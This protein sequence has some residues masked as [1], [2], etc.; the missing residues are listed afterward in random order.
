[1]HYLVGV[2]MSS[3]DLGCGRRVSRL[4]AVSIVIFLVMSLIAC[5]GGS[6][7][8]TPDQ[9]L[10]EKQDPDN[11]TPHVEFVVDRKGG[12]FEFNAAENS[13]VKITLNIPENTL[14]ADQN[15]TASM[16]ENYPAGGNIIAG[17]VFDLKPEN[18]TFSSPVN[19]TIFYDHEQLNGIPESALRMYLLDDGSWV[20]IA[21]SVDSD[22]HSLSVDIT[23]LGVYA[24]GME[25]ITPLTVADPTG[26]EFDSIFD[27]R[28]NCTDE[29]GA[30]CD[31]IYYTVDGT[32]PTEA[33]N[34]YIEA[35]QVANSLTTL[36]YFATDRAGNKEP[37]KTQQYHINNISTFKIN[38]SVEGLSGTLQVQLNE[39]SPIELT[40][41]GVFSFVDDILDGAE[42]SVS[43][44]THPEGQLC[45]LS[46]AQGVIEG[47]NISDVGIVCNAINNIFT[48]GGD[49]IGLSGG[50]L[51]LEHDGERH[52]ITQDGSFT[53]NSI[54]DSN[55]AYEVEIYRQPND[56]ICTIVNGK[57]VI[58]S[59]S[60]TD[61]QVSCETKAVSFRIGG[62][63]SGLVDSITLK[64]GDQ[65][66]TIYNNG[67]YM[68]DEVFLVGDSYDVK[69]V[70]ESAGEVCSLS[71]SSG[72]IDDTNITNINVSCVTNLYTLS[73]SISGLIE[74]VEIQNSDGQ[75]LNLS[76]NGEFIFQNQLAHG[77]SYNVTVTKLPAGFD[78]Q[79]EH[80]S[81]RISAANVSS[82]I[83]SCELDNTPPTPPD[84]SHLPFIYEPSNRTNDATPTWRW[85]SSGGGNGVFRYKLNDNV[86]WSDETTNRV[87]T[88]ENAL[89]DGEHVFHVQERDNA[90]NWS[91][92]STDTVVIETAP[93]EV[94]STWPPLNAQSIAPNTVISSTFS[95][96]VIWYIGK[97]GL[98]NRS[99]LTL[100]DSQGNLINAETFLVPSEGGQIDYLK[101][102]IR[103]FDPLLENETYKATVTLTITD[104]FGN[105]LEAPFVWNFSTR[106]PLPYYDNAANWNDYLLNDANSLLELS[107]AA[108]D[109]EIP[110]AR[111]A[112]IH[113]GN[114]RKFFVPEQT[115]CTTLVA[116]DKLN[117]F[118]WQCQEADNGVLF[119]STDLQA[120]V[121]LSDLI[122]NGTWNNNA[123][124]VTDSE[125]STIIFNSGDEVWWS[126]PI[127]VNPVGE[128]SIDLNSSGAI[129][130]IDQPIDKN[131]NINSNNVALIVPQ[132]REIRSTNNATSLV[133]AL[134]KR[135][136]WLEGR[137][138]GNG[139]QQVVDFS[140]VDFSVLRHITTYGGLNA[141]IKLSNGSDMNRIE[142]VRSHLNN[143]GLVLNQS[144]N[145]SII[146]TRFTMNSS[147][148]IDLQQANNNQLL[149]MM[150]NINKN[151]ISLQNSNTN[152]L[153]NVTATHNAQ[154]AVQLSE[155]SQN[156]SLLNLTLANNGG[157][158]VR[159]ESNANYNLL[160]NLHAVNNDYDGFFASDINGVTVSNLIVTDNGPTASTQAPY[161]VF[162]VKLINTDF[163]FTGEMRAGFNGTGD[164][165][166]LLGEVINT[167]CQALN[168]SDHIFTDSLSAKSSFIGKLSTNNINSSDVNGRA[169]FPNEPQNFDWHEFDSAWQSW[170]ADGFATYQDTNIIST[171]FDRGNFGCSNLSVMNVSE[172]YA[173]ASTWHD[174]AVIWDWRFAETDNISS[175]VL[176]LYLSGSELNTLSHLWS[177]SSSTFLRNAVEVIGDMNNN[178][179]LI[180]NDNGLCESGEACIYTPHIGAYQGQGTLISAGEF[181]NGALQ[182]IKLNAY[183]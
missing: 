37:V 135:F 153:L 48:L 77:T 15:I 92:S 98:N 82:V 81:G 40:S 54:F 17:T 46:N 13:P 169:L 64:N 142:Q 148:G 105:T 166:E 173:T 113:A 23:R 110:F 6:D 115:A 131:I 147:L 55:S 162:G 134:N 137:L 12:L 31:K 175:G 14:S 21:N 25:L 9:N 51:V 161:E 2:A 89:A 5:G 133:S 106:E 93:L 22:N 88:P 174:N 183:E 141:G 70:Q 62:Q 132:D 163:S 10:N 45:T 144:S 140:N 129:Y 151:G 107:G 4:L 165:Y 39:G 104:W 7:S 102:E 24:V 38:G 20:E 158:G 52:S 126:N 71:N 139:S 75:V 127:I 74:T 57:G 33:S 44:S 34:I 122:N 18:L 68:F 49:V 63:V 78:C 35:I 177:D 90:G 178:L 76:E 50:V 65:T 149:D 118:Q 41:N 172:C 42:Y 112:C 27:I 156:N 100:E 121:T 79:L 164:C 117:A 179:E 171:L 86:S 103:P 29:G 61:I 154:H 120:E 28:L 84:V 99:F 116:Q 146:D 159:V 181:V 128:S 72:S 160:K 43:I 30:G 26:G 94:I 124:F 96:K 85:V 91:E 36:K 150:I 182:N 108:C 138:S 69:L 101:I 143:T 73:G 56:Q 119:I 167:D 97:A 145:N 180:G 8:K 66:K 170:G 114:M 123:L 152:L 109:G 155:S 53:L 3:F 60:K 111:N 83:I 59:I 58:D 168:N 32:D 125:S 157:S 130:V 11:K 136:L 80:N 19:V 47:A 87:Y 67:S 95:N 1:M 16:R 176:T